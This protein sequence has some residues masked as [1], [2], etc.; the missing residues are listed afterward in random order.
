MGST[1][2]SQSPGLLLHNID[3]TTLA[4]TTS[5]TATTTTR[6]YDYIIIGIG[7]AGKSAY[8]TLRKKNPSATIALVDPFLPSTK[9]KSHY[10]NAAS[11]IDHRTR[12]VY[13]SSSSSS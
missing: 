6:T 8:Q 7:K 12:T 5:T 3:K 13:I 9:N 4:S 10:N 11:R 2:I 1:Q